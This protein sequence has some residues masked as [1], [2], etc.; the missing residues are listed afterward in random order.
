VKAITYHNGTLRAP[1]AALE[2]DEGP[3]RLRRTGDAVWPPRARAYGGEFDGLRERLSGPLLIAARLALPVLLLSTLLGAAYLYT[4]AFLL[5]PAAPAVVQQALLTIGDLIVPMAWYSIHLTNRRLGASYAFGQLGAAMVLIALAA[6]SNP[7]DIDNWVNATPALT[8]RAVLAFCAAFPL[9]NF[10]AITVF[11]CARG[12]R[13]WSAPLAASFAASLAFSAV[14]YP[15][16]FAGSGQVAWA[17]AALVH[18]ALF[19]GVSVL[20]LAPYYLL[21]PAMRPISGL[22]G[23]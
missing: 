7:W 13:W 3:Y 5:L 8:P 16:A 17:D 9:A 10:V 1:V 23:Y 12:P 15:A 20:L 18:F 21:R 4:D 11:D 6:L 22:N 19:L 2:A 14:Y